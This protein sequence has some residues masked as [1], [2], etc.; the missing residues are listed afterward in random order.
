MSLNRSL[1]TQITED[2]KNKKKPSKPRV[3]RN[4]W[5]H[6]GEVTTIPSNNITM[7][8]V[9]YPVLGVPNVGPAQM[10]QPD[11][12]Y[13]FPGARNVVEYPM[14]QPGGQTIAYGDNTRIGTVPRYSRRSNVQPQDFSGLMKAADVA[15]DIMQLGHF[16]PTPLTQGMA[17]AGDFFGAGIDGYQAMEEGLKGNYRAAG[18]NAASAFLPGYLKSQGY[19]RSAA[20]ATPGSIAERIAK[21]G[22]G[23]GNYRPLTALPRLTNNPVIKKGINANRSVAG[24]LAAETAYDQYKQGGTTYSGGVWYQDGGVPK[25]QFAGA[26][27]TNALLQNINKPKTPQ[28]LAAHRQRIYNTIRPSDYYDQ[29]NYMRYL[30][31]NQREERDDTRSEEAFRQYLGLNTKPA[32]ITPAIYRPTKAKDPNAK[33]Y[34]VDK[35]LEQ[36]LF[37]SFHDKVKLGE[38][39]GTD[40]FQ[41][42]HNIPYLKWLADQGLYNEENN[43]YHLTK[44]DQKLKRSEYQ[45]RARVLGNFTV[46]HG[47]DDKGEYLSYYD[48]YDFP[49]L[50]QKQMQGTPYE[51][52]GRI[53]YPKKAKGGQT[54]DEREMVNGIA[55]ILS[56]VDSEENRERIARKMMEDFERENV[57]YDPEKFK[58]MSRLQGGGEQEFNDPMST[59]RTL[60]KSIDNWQ[61]I[62]TTDVNSVRNNMINYMKSPLYAQRQTNYPEEYIG[63]AERYQKKKFETAIANNKVQQRINNLRSTPI[64]FAKTIDLNNDYFDPVNKKI[65]LNSRGDLTTLAHEM[66]HAGIRNGRLASDYVNG[67]YWDTVTDKKKLGPFSTSL[68]KGEVN[69]FVTLARPLQADSIFENDEHEDKDTNSERFADESYSDLMGVRELLHKKGYTKNFGDNISKELIDKALKDKNIYDDFIFRRMHNKYGTDNLIHLNN[70]IAS[71]NIQSGIPMAKYGG[72]LDQYQTG[73]TK[74]TVQP[75]QYLSQIA[76]ANNV[77]VDDLV[78][79]NQI[80]NPNLIKPGQELLIPQGANQFRMPGKDGYEGF[81][82]LLARQKELSAMPARDMIREFRKRTQMEGNYAV[83]DKATGNM[84]IYNPAGE[85]LSSFPVGTGKDFGDKR[86]INVKGP[87]RRNTTPGGIYTLTNKGTGRDS[88]APKYGNNI[89]ELVDQNNMQQP[90]ALHQVPTDLQFRNTIIGDNDPTNNRIS[91][92][93]INCR[94]KD[95]DSQVERYMGKGNQIYVLPDDPNNK[96]V[97]RNNKIMLTGDK[98]DPDVSYS[99]RDLT[100][101]P[102]QIKW[103]QSQFTTP[104]ATDKQAIQR[105]APIVKKMAQSIVDNK[106]RLM[107]DLNID[108]DTFNQIAQLSLGVSGQES[109]YGNHPLYQYKESE[110]GQNDVIMYKRLKNLWNFKSP[111]TVSPSS[112]GFTQVKYESQNKDVRNLFAKY[113]IK[114]PDDLADPSKSNI[115]TIIMMGYMH[116][117]ELPQLKKQMQKLGVSKMDALLYLNQGKRG[118][119]TKGTATPDQ[120][121]YIQNVKK[122]AKRFVLNQKRQ[123]GGSQDNWLEKYN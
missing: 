42:V 40:E 122:Y 84:S 67:K 104:Y 65:S 116:N 63:D 29:N 119:I 16:I 41:V 88:Y 8:G 72:W 7:D 15:T 76:K 99:K 39:M 52:Y 89:W 113:G 114:S 61:N 11:G 64:S 66:T 20:N 51:V 120:N 102:I 50:I 107:R 115:A 117:N 55:D 24:A 58:K 101:K 94:K 34:K 43:S 69:Q 57:T 85:E 21:L 32:F 38:T 81:D 5:Q 83:V 46:S 87:N 23:S 121:N 74:Y 90:T 91:N 45:S 62:S 68:N 35:L 111:F 92:G 44:T 80:T 6:P 4:Q 71:N 78:L 10:M 100:A 77:S 97:V 2:L 19:L 105:A 13:H 30:F 56:Q 27:S 96:L 108:N 17:F 47:K 103:A 33:Y 53:Y 70:T 37:D 60:S 59:F 31:N 110:E 14:M 1:L 54:R 118:E 82:A 9:S 112:R 79:A 28:E 12:Q 75:G 49:N 22:L 73:G 86:T 18:I 26:V 25:M 109:D 98:F 36:D 106:Q 48:T 95:F 123:E 93:C 3:P